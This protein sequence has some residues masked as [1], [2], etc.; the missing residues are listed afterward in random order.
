MSCTRKRSIS[1]RTA[2]EENSSITIAVNEK[3]SE[4]VTID[5]SQWMTNL[6]EPLTKIPLNKLAIPG[7]H[8]SGAYYLDPNT[9]V[10]SGICFCFVNVP[11][12]VS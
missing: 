10:S 4:S 2:C 9:P 11:S 3:E 12:L 7:S 5:L 6:P 1:Y 8:D